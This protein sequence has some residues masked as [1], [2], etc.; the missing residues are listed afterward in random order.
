MLGLFDVDQRLADDFIAEDDVF[1]DGERGY[2][3]E[4]LMNHA[5]ATTNGIVGALDVDDFA[6]EQDFSFV[7][8]VQ[9]IEHV[10][11]CGFAC[12]VFAQERVN[13]ARIEAEVDCVI[14]HNT[15]EALG[16]VS[17]FEDWCHRQLH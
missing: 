6:V 9:S 11:Q 8:P 16:E 5:Q 17:Y 10:H 12:A 13:F 4:V 7:G 1:G 3:H 2:K 15:G 14:G